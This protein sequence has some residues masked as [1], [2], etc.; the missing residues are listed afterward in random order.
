[1]RKFRITLATTTAAL[2]AV[3]AMGLAAPADA[4]VVV[5]MTQPSGCC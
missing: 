3:L 1:M 2:A 4:H 5:R